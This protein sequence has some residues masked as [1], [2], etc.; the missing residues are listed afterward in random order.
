MCRNTL[1]KLFVPPVSKYVSGSE[2]DLHLAIVNS[3]SAFAENRRSNNRHVVMM[4]LPEDSDLKGLSV[5]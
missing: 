5:I 2:S 3:K 1:P 4:C